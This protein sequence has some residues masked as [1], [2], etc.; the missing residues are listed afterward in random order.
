MRR[1]W[2][3]AAPTRTWSLA[4]RAICSFE[5]WLTQLPTRRGALSLRSA[6]R[7]E[8]AVIRPV[9]GF[10]EGIFSIFR[11]NR[12]ESLSTSIVWQLRSMVGSAQISIIVRSGPMPASERA[13]ATLTLAGKPG[14]PFPRT[15]GKHTPGL[16]DPLDRNAVGLEIGRTGQA[17]R[18]LASDHAHRIDP[19]FGSRSHGIEPKEGAGRHDDLPSPRF[20]EL[21]QV[22]SRQQSTRR[23][24]HDLLSRFEHR[25]ANP[26]Q[27]C[28]GR[29]F[30][31]ELGMR[32]KLLRLDQAARDPL[33]VEPGLRLCA[34]ARGCTG[35][36]QPRYA[37]GQPAR[38]H[39]PDG[40]EAGNRDAGDLHGRASDIEGFWDGCRAY[41]APVA[42]VTSARSSVKRRLDRDRD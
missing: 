17:A 38:K 42:S 8:S 2:A 20:R 3:R 39:A 25:A 12:A 28:S 26:L 21:D 23:Q 13:A 41:Y 32:R 22:G 4:Q 7:T 10:S 33:G 18:R 24:H 40:A 31:G 11:A 29:A 9:F 27:H 37:V 6:A 5:E 19:P 14:R 1:G 15:A 36:R 30:D 16:V 35:K 34:V